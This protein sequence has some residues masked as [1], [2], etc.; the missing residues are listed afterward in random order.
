LNFLVVRVFYP[1]RVRS[2]G[3]KTRATD[4]SYSIA[5][6]TPQPPESCG[7]KSS[8]AARPALF[9]AQE[10]ALPPE[11]DR[12]LESRYNRH[13]ALAIVITLER[14]LP[15]PAPAAVYAKSGTGKALARESDRL[16]FAARRK[17]VEPLTSLLSENQAVLRAQMEAEGFDPSKMRL[18][19]EAWFDPANGLKTIRALAEH[20]SSNLNDF[21]QPNPILRDL[22]A[23]E[24][25]LVV[26]EAAGVRFHFTKTDL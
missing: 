16:D 2:H 11:A 8:D 12:P 22:K 21:K 18:P 1:C 23:A 26:A 20:V 9:G 14:D 17:S 24:A 5:L 7:V 3:L 25:L 13:M 6:Q 15:N 10:V 4:A 19:P